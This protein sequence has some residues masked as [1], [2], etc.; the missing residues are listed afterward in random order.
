MCATATVRPTENNY[1]AHNSLGTALD[2]K[3]QVDEAI[4]QYREALR[5]KSGYPEALY[6]LGNWARQEGRD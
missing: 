5:L 4:S 3:N 1:L 6:N 2:A